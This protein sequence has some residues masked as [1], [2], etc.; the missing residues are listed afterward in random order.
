MADTATRS[1]YLKALLD[2]VGCAAGGGFVSIG[3]VTRKGHFDVIDIEVEPEL[4]KVRQVKIDNKE[5]LRLHFYADDRASP[6]ISA[7]RDDFP[8]GHVHTSLT[9][10]EHG[11]FLCVWEENWH[12]L[13]R[14]LT[15]QILVERIRA[16]L[17]R[18]ATGTIHAEG[19]GVEPLL[20]STAD[21]LLVPADSENSDWQVTECHDVG[22]VRYY[23]VGTRTGKGP[24]TGTALPTF[25]ATA[26]I[27]THGALGGHPTDLSGLSDMVGPLGIDLR[28]MLAEWVG[29][30]EKADKGE[31]KFLIVIKF[32]MTTDA[33]PPLETTEIW[34]FIPHQAIGTIGEGLGRAFYEN[35]LIQTKVGGQIN[36]EFNVPIS[37][38]RV[39]YR[40]RDDDAR[41]YS[42]LGEVAEQSI[43]AIGAGALGSNIVANTAKLGVIDWTVIDD[44]ATLPHNLVRQAHPEG[45]TGKSKAQGLAAV[46]NGLRGKVG[47]SA[48]IADILDPGDQQ[49]AVA[50]VLSTSDLV[51]D[52]SASPAVLGHLSDQENVSR[53][54]SMF[55]SPDGHDLVA[56]FESEGRGIKIDEL[57]AQYILAAAISSEM[58]GHFDESRL[59]FIRYT[60]ACQN[61]SRP[62]APWKVQTLSA[63]AS[64]ALIE[65]DGNAMA[66]VWRLREDGSVQLVEIDS[67][68]PVRITLGDW[69]ATFSTGAA[70]AMRAY[71]GANL[72]NETG[73]ILLGTY[74][75]E[76]S[77]VHVLCALPAPPDSE[78][79]P[80]HFIRGAKTL[81]PMVDAISE[82][83]VGM[84]GYLG[85]WH[86]HPP[87]S[88]ARPSGH[89][90]KLFS[91]LETNIAPTGAPYFMTIINDDEIWLRGGWLGFER[92]ESSFAG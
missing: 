22:S 63:L 30:P 13:K 91:Y 59:D 60:N 12:D 41:R 5:P 1:R 18:M 71:R 38:V 26:A 14:K 90:E 21:V 80:T 70:N 19:Q 75:F 87:G 55:F 85:E 51:V 39:I 20:P 10:N 47:T 25:A 37:A 15:G 61:L 74:D 16:W 88:L 24:A 45:L 77:V 82:R 86:S 31:S 78:Q 27:Q 4:P 49:E 40:L 7:L 28:P 8:L 56:L 11:V 9:R 46:A 54:A 43:T 76:R 53:A 2:Y 81:K 73:G 57:E 62:L 32:P 89:D 23:H 79:S 33:E 72:P 6:L 35:N 17:T 52:L 50:T 69:R 36:P 67:E 29:Q 48:I 92:S 58:Q 84:I 65:Q 42:G 34:A 83:S 3:P 66:R 68:P 44:D 64:G